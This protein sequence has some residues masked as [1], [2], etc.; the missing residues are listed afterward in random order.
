VM[1]RAFS[2]FSYVAF[3]ASFLYFIAFVVGFVPMREAGGGVLAAIAIDVALV[4]FF[5]VTHSI[6]ARARFKRWIT[7]FIPA[8]AERSLFVLVASAQVALLCWQWRPLA[9]PSLWSAAP[10]LSTVLT[11]LQ[12]VGFAICLVS[13]LLIDHLELFGLRQAFGPRRS[14][15]PFQTPLLYRAVRHPLYLGLFIALWA[16]PD[17]TVGRLVLALGLTLYTVVGAH[18]EERDLA[19]HFGDDYRRYQREVPMLVP[20]PRPRR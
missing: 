7:R 17:M 6:M 11:G 13:T 20:L 19:A 16:A 15:I 18:L 10:P 1:L 5:G 8:A 3:Q 9:G 2:G 12:L 4:A 14:P